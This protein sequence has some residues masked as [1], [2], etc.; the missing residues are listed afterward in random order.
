MSRYFLLVLRFTNLISH[1]PTHIFQQTWLSSSFIHVSPSK[2]SFTLKK[3][4]SVDFAPV[5]L[6][7]ALNHMESFA[8]FFKLWKAM[9]DHT[10]PVTVIQINKM[11][12][13]IHI[14]L[15]KKHGYSYH[16]YWINNKMIKLDFN[17]RKNVQEE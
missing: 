14:I 1:L 6:M 7:E 17:V 4:E 2:N 12:P 15:L 9:G 5:F 16:S 13:W 10:H 3:W 11:K 8:D